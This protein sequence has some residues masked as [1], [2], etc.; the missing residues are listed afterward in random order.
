MTDTVV[1]HDLRTG[2]RQS[3]KLSA[4]E[5]AA[6]ERHRQE[7]A[8]ATAAQQAA[9]AKRQ[10]KLT[11]AREA[12]HKNDLSQAVL[13]NGLSPDMATFLSALLCKIQ[14]LEAEILELRG[15]DT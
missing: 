12:D 2:K 10:Q 5:Q 8:A 9:V 7:A 15:L 14:R 11:T 6:L 4:T 1:E 13:P 3:R